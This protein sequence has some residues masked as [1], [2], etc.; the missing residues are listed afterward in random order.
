MPEML[1]LLFGI[2]EEKKN[3]SASFNLKRDKKKDI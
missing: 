3:L 1:Q 2:T